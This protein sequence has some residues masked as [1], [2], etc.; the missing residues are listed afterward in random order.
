MM[1]CWIIV[2]PFPFQYVIELLVMI[3]LLIAA[4]GIVL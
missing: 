4:V 2:F 3:Q 1:V